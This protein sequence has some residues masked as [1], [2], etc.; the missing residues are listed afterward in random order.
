MTRRATAERM[1]TR[2]A[3]AERDRSSLQS[4]ATST[5]LLPLG[6]TATS[7]EALIPSAF[8]PLADSVPPSFRMLPHAQ[9]RRSD[10]ASPRMPVNYEFESVKAAGYT[11]GL[12]SHTPFAPGWVPHRNVATVPQHQTLSSP[13]NMSP[14][15]LVPLSPN[16]ASFRH[17][18]RQLPLQPPL[19]AASH[20]VHAAHAGAHADVRRAH[21]LHVARVM[22]WAR[23]M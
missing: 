7:T 4:A 17:E 13:R 19:T 5:F 16:T 10:D 1:P 6:R 18:M 11:V 8:H 14:R 20:A 23:S 22:Q 3:T 12:R 15:P 9:H 21:A 2:Q